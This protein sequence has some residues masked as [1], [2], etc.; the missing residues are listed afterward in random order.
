MWLETVMSGEIE[1]GGMKADGI[2][3]PLEHGA[4]QVV[5]EQDPRH[6][7]PGIEGSG[8]TAQKV[9]HTRIEEEAQEDLARVAQHHDESH[10]RA[11]CTADGEVPEM[12]PIDLGLFARQGAQAQIGFRLGARPVTRDQVTEMAEA[13]AIAAL[14]HHRIEAAGGEGWK[15]L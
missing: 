8:M 2:A 13:A 6:A 15:G 12:P 5:V 4:L 14:A 3:P 7:A 1:Q 10:Q 9:L 11:P